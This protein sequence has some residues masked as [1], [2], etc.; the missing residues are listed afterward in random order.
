M[1]KKKKLVTFIVCLLI[2]IVCAT[3]TYI[4]IICNLKD[5]SILLPFSCIFWGVMTLITGMEAFAIFSGPGLKEK[6][7]IKLIDGT[8]SCLKWKDLTFSEDSIKI[9]A[10]LNAVP[11]TLECWVDNSKEWCKVD[12]GD[13]PCNNMLFVHHGYDDDTDTQP[14]LFDALGFKKEE[15]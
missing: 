9:K 7:D 1:T 15:N 2:V 14:N 5:D 3:P 10:T 4:L 11:V 12:F 8:T 13:A 6:S